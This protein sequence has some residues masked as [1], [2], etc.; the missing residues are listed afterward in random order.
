M[1]YLCKL[2]GETDS[3][4]FPK[5]LK[6]RCKS[7]RSLRDKEYYKSNKEVLI[8]KA[9][10]RYRTKHPDSRINNLQKV[11]ES[12]KERDAI[13]NK[14]WRSANKSHLNNH[15]NHYRKERR[16]VDSAFSFT[17]TLRSRQGRV[18]KGKASTTKGLGCTSEELVQHLMLQFQTGMTLE[19]YGEWHIDHILP[20]ASHIKDSEGNWCTSSEYN[21]KLIHY[22]NLQPLWADDNIKKSDTIVGT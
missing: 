20:L 16:K 10:D 18:L 6:G 15:I 14:Q 1:D 13:R 8:A 7:C 3:T 19:N 5:R 11:G 4:K 2:C 9:V 12:K 17:C 21:K 22:T